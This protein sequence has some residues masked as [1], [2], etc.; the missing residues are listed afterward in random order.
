M[1][2]PE[3]F[4]AKVWLYPGDTAN[5]HFVTVPKPVG[6]AM[7]EK[8]R[9]LTKGFGS[10]PVVVTIG[11]TTWNTSVFPDKFSGSYLLPLKASVR[12]REAIY[13]EDVV[14]VSFQVST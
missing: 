1:S 11:N 12:K 2:K 9:G 6:H 3:A 5:W 4:S 8:Y 10:L 7:K 13:V 14:T